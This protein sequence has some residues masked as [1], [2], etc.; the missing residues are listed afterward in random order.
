MRSRN[1]Q[2]LAV[3]GLMTALTVVVLIFSNVITI[4][5]YTFPAG[6][7]ILLLL[8]SYAVGERWAY[9][10]FAAAS[11][12][13]FLLCNDKEAVLCFVLFFGYYP[14]LRGRLEHCRSRVLK[15][16]CKLALFNGALMAVYS[17]AVY[18]FG[19]P[20]NLE[21]FGVDL[22][23]V[24]LAVFNVIFLIY[25]YALMALEVNHRQRIEK[26]IAKLLKR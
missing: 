6:A 26:L 19:I 1:T 15:W 11:L 12:T 9:Y 18:V 24:F 8:L 3:S 23:M 25:D 17:L 20:E 13:G 7:G 10:S 21:L 16:M 14:L 2:K 4:G 22:P 5:T